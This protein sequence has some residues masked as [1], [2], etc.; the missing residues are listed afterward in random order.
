MRVLEK[1]CVFPPD[2]KVDGDLF[3]FVSVTKPST[4]LA[5]LKESIFTIY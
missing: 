4:G 1:M 2:S 3:T 5:F